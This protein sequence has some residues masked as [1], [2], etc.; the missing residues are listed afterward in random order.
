MSAKPKAA[1][2]PYRVPSVRML[3]TRDAQ[4]ELKA[5]GDPNDPNVQK[6][7]SLMDKQF[8]QRTAKFH[9]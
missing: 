9:S 2:K 7:L 3:D 1:K 8:N 4:A 5:R 6:M